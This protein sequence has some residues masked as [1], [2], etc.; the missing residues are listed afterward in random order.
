MLR[1]LPDDADIY[2]PYGATECL[3]VA[4]IG[5]RQVLEETAAQTAEGAGT[6]VGTVFDQMEVRIIRTTFEPIED[7]SQAQQLTDVDIGEIIVRGPVATREYF[8]RPDAT[9]MAKIADDDGQTFWHRMGDV[10][11]FD[12]QRR[13][14]FCGRKAHIVFAASGPMYSVR[15]EAIFNQ[16]PGIYRTALVGL[17]E[18]GQQTPVIVAEPE[19][20][21]FPADSS[22]KQQLI[23]ELLQLGQGN[24]MTADIRRV[25]LRQALPVDTRHNIKIK[26]EQLALWAA[27]N[28]ST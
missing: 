5:G 27:K 17:G 4:A 15:C 11:Y 18:K 28:I 10:G 13:L 1:T 19:A 6:C 2:T 25:I 20:G 26:R 23:D 22:S 8:R 3:P 9:A 7:I 16:H 24:P 21:Q 12:D 14:W